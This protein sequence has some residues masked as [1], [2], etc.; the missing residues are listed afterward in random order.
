MSPLVA[1]SAVRGSRGAAAKCSQCR[2]TAAGRRAAPQPLETLTCRPAWPHPILS[3]S[4]PA[5][6]TSDLMLQ[7]GLQA[8]P[9]TGQSLVQHFI[10]WLVGGIYL[11]PFLLHLVHFLFSFSYSTSISF[12]SFPSS[13]PFFSSLYSLFPVLHPSSHHPP[14]HFFLHQH[15]LLHSALSSFLFSCL[16]HSFSSF[17]LLLLDL[18]L[19]IPI[20]LPSPL[21]L[22]FSPSP[23][24]APPSLS[25]TLQI[26]EPEQQCRPKCEYASLTQ[27][28]KLTF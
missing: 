4:Q 1:L 17:L 22:P 14:L 27:N 13:C 28:A 6:S 18:L 12:S 24:G 21:A 2:L 26:G 11:L 19:L 3:H 8:T 15:L 16:S 25:L 10:C 20:L 23:P 5:A 9:P 7:V